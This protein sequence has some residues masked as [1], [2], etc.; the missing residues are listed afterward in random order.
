MIRERVLL[1]IP[2]PA[3][4][5]TYAAVKANVSEALELK[6]EVL[7]NFEGVWVAP[8]TRP[9][10]FRTFAA[11]RT[12]FEGKVGRGSGLQRLAPTKQLSSAPPVAMAIDG[13]VE[14][15]GC[16]ACY[17]EALHPGP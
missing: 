2:T 9:P 7:A 17:A 15:A 4:M 1:G 10:E 16:R 12:T 14:A 13:G 3:R 8:A 5:K 6:A 11:W